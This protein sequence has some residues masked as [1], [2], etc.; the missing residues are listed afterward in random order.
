MKLVPFPHLLPLVLTLGMISTPRLQNSDSTKAWQQTLKAG[1]L[2]GTG[3]T[4]LTLNG[5]FTK[6][7]QG[8]GSV[9]PSLAVDCT[10]AKHSG[11]ARRK[12]GAAT[13]LAG[14]TLKIDYVEPQEVHGTS[15]Y[16]KVPVRYRL[17]DARE[18]RD[19]WPSG[20]DKTSA[21][22]S[23]DLLKRMLRAHTVV[24]TVSEA[25]ASEVAMRFEMPD[26]APVEEGCGIAGHK[27]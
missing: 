9:R 21:S 16:T 23:K 2:P 12:F 17:D 6:F 24:I 19:E 13:L 4:R 3:R 18:Q 1:D 11:G 22:I 25:Q 27:K 7:P 5:K 10:I 8:E 26:P 15:Y 14:T 20:A